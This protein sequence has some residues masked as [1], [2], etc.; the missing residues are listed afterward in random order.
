MVEVQSG[1]R[2]QCNVAPLLGVGVGVDEEKDGVASSL[3]WPSMAT[4][5][6]PE[7]VRLH[8]LPGFLVK[9]LAFPFVAGRRLNSTY[10][11]HFLFILAHHALTA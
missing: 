6:N 1:S 11:K 2:H 7:R 3:Y 5:C 4:L 10:N 9:R 8:Q